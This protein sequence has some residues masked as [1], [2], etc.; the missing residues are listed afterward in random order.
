[1]SLFYNKNI[2]EKDFL[3]LYNSIKNKVNEDKRYIF[4]GITRDKCEIGL[5]YY[6]VWVFKKDK[7]ENISLL[8]PH[9]LTIFLRLGYHQYK[10]K[11]NT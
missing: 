8:T 1:M 10:N 2:S 7:E 5:I 6:N 11:Y 9:H 4:N 3:N